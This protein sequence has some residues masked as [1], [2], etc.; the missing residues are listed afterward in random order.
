M[1]NHGQFII[2]IMKRLPHRGQQLAVAKACD[3]AILFGILEYL[4]GN[5]S[6]RLPQET[7][8]AMYDAKIAE[9]D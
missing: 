1:N 9:L 5:E 6:L 8:Q 7:L 4:R 3:A 2:P